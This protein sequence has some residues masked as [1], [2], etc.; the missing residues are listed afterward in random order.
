MLRFLANIRFN[1][2]TTLEQVY[3]LGDY[4]WLSLNYGFQKI[5][6]G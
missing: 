3:L 6:Q 1:Y 5:V 2:D 4:S